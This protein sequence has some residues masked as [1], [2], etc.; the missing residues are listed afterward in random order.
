MAQIEFRF[1]P[2]ALIDEDTGDITLSLIE[3]GHTPD[4]V[5]TKTATVVVPGAVIASL[6]S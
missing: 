2:I 1:Y 5:P 3:A 6:E 4:F